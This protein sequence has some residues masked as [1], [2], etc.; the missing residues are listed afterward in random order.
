MSTN[1]T[2]TLIVVV[3]VLVTAVMLNLLSVGAAYGVLVMV[4]QW[5]WGAGLIGLEGTAPTGVGRRRGLVEPGQNYAVLESPAVDSH[6]GDGRNAAR[7]S[8]RNPRSSESATPTSS[9]DP[10]TASRS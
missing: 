9:A 4:F 8:N 3:A 7:D 1:P 6:H 5:G 10:K 2:A